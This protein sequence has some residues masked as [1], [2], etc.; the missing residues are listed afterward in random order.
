[1]PTL[2]IATGELAGRQFD[3]G[4]DRFTIGRSDACSLVLGL[5]AV[6][7]EHCA[8]LRRGARYAVQDSGSTNGTLLNGSQ[9]REALL[10][11]GD[12]IGVGD[13]EILFRDPAAAG[14]ASAS[15]PAFQAR[16]RTSWK[17]F[18]TG[19]LVAAVVI[20]AALWFAMRLMNG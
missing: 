2:T 14:Q 20:L 3:L 16:K 1:M 9:V 15:Y 5:S 6:S 12:L 13:I 4:P 7:V 18:L 17:G 19:L 8:I 10:K 11:D